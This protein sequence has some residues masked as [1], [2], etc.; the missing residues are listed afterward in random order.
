M[1]GNRI[2]SSLLQLIL[3]TFL[4]IENYFDEKPY[5]GCYS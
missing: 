5:I 4:K 1:I 2:K 3:C